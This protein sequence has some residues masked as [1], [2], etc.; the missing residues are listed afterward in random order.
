MQQ[1][2]QMS[3]QIIPRGAEWLKSEMIQIKRG[4]PAMSMLLN[5]VE[6]ASLKQN[7]PFELSKK[8][9]LEL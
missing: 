3:D 2:E 4:Q 9:P 7:G 5:I 6:V 8:T 1:L